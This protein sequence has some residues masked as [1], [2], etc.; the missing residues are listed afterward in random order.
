MNNLIKTTFVFAAGAAVGAAVALL[1]APKSGEQLRSQIVDL[2]NDAQKRVQDYCEQ[3]KQDLTQANTP[4]QAPVET[5]H[6]A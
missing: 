2:A 6:P 5:E 3:L 1:L 4:A